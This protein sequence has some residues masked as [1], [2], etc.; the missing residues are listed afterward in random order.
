MS[1]TIRTTYML[2]TH[3]C[4]VSVQIYC[5]SKTRFGLM[6]E[7]HLIGQIVLIM[8]VIWCKKG[9]LLRNTPPFI[10]Y[11]KY[12]KPYFAKNIN[13]TQILEPILGVSTN[14]CIRSYFA[15]RRP[16]ANN[17]ATNPEMQEQMHKI[18]FC[19]SKIIETYTRDVQK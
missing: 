17:A 3:G 11:C 15:N 16:Y 14:T 4:T 18:F 2:V 6:P 8:L 5:T 12:V 9:L 19:Q 13:P 1:A 7:Y 10:H